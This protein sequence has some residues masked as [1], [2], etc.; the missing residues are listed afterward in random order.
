METLSGKGNIT[1]AIITEVAN[2]FGT[3]VYLYEA[4]LISEKCDNILSMPNKYGLRVRY[5]MKANSSSAILQYITGKGLHIDLSSLNEGRRAHLAGIPYNKMM[6]TTQEVP[7]GKDRS[8]LERMIEEGMKYNVC[9]LRQLELIADFASENNIPLSMRIHPGDGGSGESATRNTGDKYSCFGVHLTDIEKALSYAKSKRLI[10]DQVHVHIGS[11]GD[12]EKWR[13]NI[14]RELGFVEKYFPNAKT[15]NFGGG[16]KEARMPE[17]TPAD[18]QDLGLYAKKKIE[19]FYNRTRRKLL[20]EI[21]PGTY[22]MAISG[23]LV[24]EIIDKKQTGSD[25]FEFL[26]LSGGMEVNSRPLNYGSKHPFYIVSKDGKLLSSEFDLKHLD[27][28]KDKRIPVGRCCES[29]DSQSLDKHGHIVPRVMA[30]PNL[31]DYFVIGGCG[32]YC[33]SMSPFNYNSHVQ[34]PEVLLIKGELIC[35]RKRQSLK[36]MVANELQLPQRFIS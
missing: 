13:E 1:P 5:A 24:T 34:A 21:E 4:D 11:G 16:L 28:E 29:G 20:M 10:F 25:G 6:L 3:P 14:D 7:I 36:Q 9:S 35:I 18:I 12:P 32:A 17:E 22:L 26:V 33:S 30:N 8:D 19:E 2:R 27:K 31:G 15:V 23:N